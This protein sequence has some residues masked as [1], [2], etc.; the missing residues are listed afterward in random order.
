M[1]EIPA[2]FIK[3]SIEWVLEIFLIVA[4]TL[5]WLATSHKYPSDIDPFFFTSST[6]LRISFLFKSRIIIFAPCSAVANPIAFP[7]PLAPP[8]I[9][10]VLFSK[11]N[12]FFHGKFYSITENLYIHIE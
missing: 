11:L 7:I 1:W 3:T 2:Q 6:V 9:I 8:V 4:K 10:I 12:F 5:D